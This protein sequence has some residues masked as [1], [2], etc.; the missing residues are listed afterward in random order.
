[1]LSTIFHRQLSGLSGL[2]FVTLLFGGCARKAESRFD[3]EAF[4]NEKYRLVAC[5]DLRDDDRLT[6]GLVV[7]AGASRV[8]AKA[9]PTPVQLS[10]PS[11]AGVKSVTPTPPPAPT[12]EVEQHL[13]VLPFASS[14]A[15]GNRRLL[16]TWSSYNNMTV[17]TYVSNQSS[18]LRGV[19]ISPVL[20][21]ASETGRPIES[22][23]E[24]VYLDRSGLERTFIYRYPRTLDPGAPPELQYL[25]VD[26]IEAIAVAIP[27]DAK[28]V[29]IRDG[30]TAIPKSEFSNGVARFYPANVKAAGADYLEIRYSLEASK[31]AK[32]ISELILKLL[33]VLL[34]P[35]VELFLLGPADNFKPRTRKI[36]M[37]IGVVIQLAILGV[38]IWIAASVRGEL[39]EKTLSELPIIVVGAI[40]AGLVFYIKRKPADSN[41]KTA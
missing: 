19:G 15:Q 26:V 11:A 6:A 36:V 41:P 18:E 23:K 24:L 16:S 33:A 9:T 1:M 2:L 21:S 8:I 17:L 7:R 12:P 10:S 3:H 38:L 28:G 4:T 5:F 40:V 22:R 37:I 39:G 13:V 27:S 20:G 14:A 25:P 31:P 30:Q 32:V 35:C 29:E 34:V